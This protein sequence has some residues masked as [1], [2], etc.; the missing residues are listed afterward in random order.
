MSST[1]HHEVFT[2]AEIASFVADL[3]KALGHAH[4]N[5]PTANSDNRDAEGKAEAKR[6]ANDKAILRGELAREKRQHIKK[7][8]SDPMATNTDLVTA[9]GGD[10]AVTPLQLAR[11]VKADH[12]PGTLAEARLIEMA[13]HHTSQSRSPKDPE[14]AFRLHVLGSKPST[15]ERSRYAE[16]VEKAQGR[17]SASSSGNIVIDH[18][19][20][21]EGTSLVSAL[22]Y[23]VKG[24]RGR[25]PPVGIGVV[26]QLLKD[27]GVRSSLFT[28]TVIPYLGGKSSRAGKATAMT[29]P[30]RTRASSLSS[31]SSPR[32]LPQIPH[33][34]RHTEQPTDE[35]IDDI[36]ADS[37]EERENPLISQTGKGLLRRAM[38]YAE[39][40]EHGAAFDFLNDARNAKA[41]RALVKKTEA[42]LESLR[43]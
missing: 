23:L 28:S 12:T 27:G 31:L 36:L 15:Q 16:I 3:I 13:D 29:T 37:D 33:S 10:A 1:L 17:L 34:P 20:P 24:A 7:V 30:A 38:N 26:G 18:G 41:P 11:L 5:T 8:A 6:A 19:E 43:N 9:L 2:K 25:M 14:E 22:R 39:N 21:L 40:G 35:Y 32:E 42:Y 4:K